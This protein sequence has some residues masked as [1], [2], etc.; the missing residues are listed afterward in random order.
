MATMTAT[1]AMAAATTDTQA[2]ASIPDDA[3]APVHN[4]IM[5]SDGTRLTERG[6]AAT[7][8]ADAGSSAR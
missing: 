7:P 3:S 8:G 5:L 2:E 1:T 4:A 6:R